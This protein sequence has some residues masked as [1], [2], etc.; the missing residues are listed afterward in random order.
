MS[1][2]RD[3]IQDNTQSEVAYN[4]Q[5]FRI[6]VFRGMALV[7]PPLLTFVILL[8]IASSVE[9]ILN[10]IES[11]TRQATV[12][13]IDKTKTEIPVGAVPNTVAEEMIRE[14]ARR[15]LAE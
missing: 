8:W 15:K 12:W 2:Q 9:K 7:L 3:P 13:L 14:R 4:L 6:A 1:D 5:P 11:A 10:P